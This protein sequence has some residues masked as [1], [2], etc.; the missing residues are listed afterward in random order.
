MFLESPQNWGTEGNRGIWVPFPIPDGSYHSGQKTGHQGGHPGLCRWMPGGVQP[1]KSCWPSY[2]CVS[3]PQKCMLKENQPQRWGLW[4]WECP[5]WD[6]L[7]ATDIPPGRAAGECSSL[8]AIIQNID[9]R[10]R[11]QGRK[12]PCSVRSHVICLP[13]NVSWLTSFSILHSRPMLSQ[14][15]T[16]HSFFFYGWIIFLYSKNIYIKR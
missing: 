15:A 4:H 3:D 5:P 10:K 16:F 6:N 11:G 9:E 1:G 12:H 8:T 7:K 14:M 2:E 13:C